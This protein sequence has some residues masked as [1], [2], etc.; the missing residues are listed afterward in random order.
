M[1][2]QKKTIAI[3]G[4]GPSGI[5]AAL[6]ARALGH[7]VT[8]YERGQEAAAHVRA[9]D[10]VR[11]FTPWRL[12]VSSLGLRTLAGQQ[13]PLPA[14][15]V[16]PTGA[17][18][19]DD[20][21]APLAASLGESFRPGTTVRGVT[22]VGLL[23]VE[24]PGSRRRRRAPFRLLLESD[25]RESEAMADIVIDATGVYGDP[26]PVGDGGLAAVGERGA[27]NLVHYS[28]QDL[29]GAARDTFADRTVLLVGSG[30]SAATALNALG[31]LVEAHDQT[32]SRVGQALHWSSTVADSRPRG[33]AAARRAL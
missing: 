12:N 16:E 13:R 28:L 15:D 7:D 30:F 9:W 14:L 27:Q 5:E 23:K 25:G 19:V 21:L 22:K 20:Y 3:L 4:A 1:T 2:A 6:Y 18:F 24:S 11:L 33:S 32:P 10:F 26:A 8:L 17:E 29:T 31:K